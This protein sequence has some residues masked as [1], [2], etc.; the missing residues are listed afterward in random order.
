LYTTPDKKTLKPANVGGIAGGLKFLNDGL[1]FKVAADN[2][3][4][5][6]SIDNAG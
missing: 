6:G 1:L 4:L 3:G 2:H 5:Y